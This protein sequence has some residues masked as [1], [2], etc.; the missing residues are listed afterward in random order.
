[1]FNLPNLNFLQSPEWQQYIQG[2]MAGDTG[3]TPP[4][5]G[6]GAGG[7]TKPVPTN[8]YKV[9]GS[10][11]TG[12]FANQDVNPFR[13]VEGG[14]QYGAGLNASA[15]QLYDHFHRKVGLDKLAGNM[16][17]SVQ[18][19]GLSQAGLGQSLQDFLNRRNPQTTPIQP[20]A[21]NPPPPN[22]N[23]NTSYPNFGGGLGSF[24]PMLTMRNMPTMQSFD[25]MAP[26]PNGGGGA[27]PP[28]PPNMSNEQY[29][30]I[31]GVAPPQGG[32][33]MTRPTA[34]NSPQQSMFDRNNIFGN[35]TNMASNFA[36]PVARPAPTPPR[37][38]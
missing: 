23:T 28:K 33:M 29:M 35:L 25:K 13:T 30:A 19:Y 16:D 24:N 14:R 34:P 10:K 18:S 32:G 22:P 1:M 2:V 7:I 9:D 6:G 8:S 17:T 12:P 36:P 26:L 11:Y 38:M 4:W 15:G 37:G 5:M 31:C 21:I 20:P 27:L 3:L